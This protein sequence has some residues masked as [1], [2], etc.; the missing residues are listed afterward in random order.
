MYNTYV[1]VP[2]G[3]YLSDG[4]YVSRFVPTVFSVVCC[5]RQGH[6]RRRCAPGQRLCFGAASGTCAREENGCTDAR[7][8]FPIDCLLEFRGVLAC[9]A[10]WFGRSKIKTVLPQTPRYERLEALRFRD[11]AQSRASAWSG[12]RSPSAS[13]RIVVLSYR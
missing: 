2:S 4:S 10:G 11:V 7:V 12:M 1:F 8:L 9:V 5:L 13:E 6:S 3:L